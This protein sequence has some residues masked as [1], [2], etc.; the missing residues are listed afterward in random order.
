MVEL[1]LADVG[2]GTM[3]FGSTAKVL[4]KCMLKYYRISECQA[5]ET[6]AGLSSQWPSSPSSLWGLTWQSL[7]RILLSRVSASSA[8]WACFQ[9]AWDHMELTGLFSY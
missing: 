5:A 4:A 1:D 7:P 8:L 9:A 2:P 6:A 3:R